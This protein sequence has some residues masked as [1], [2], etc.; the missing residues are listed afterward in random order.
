[1]KK[2]KIKFSNDKMY[3]KLLWTKFKKLIKIKIIKSI[4]L[5]IVRIRQVDGKS[6]KYINNYKSKVLMDGYNWLNIK[7]AL[8][9]SING[10]IIIFR[11]N[12]I[13]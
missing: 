9:K 13:K 8:L 11:S 10:F 12:K 3:L 5:I 6:I 1:V 2:N 4:I 7:I